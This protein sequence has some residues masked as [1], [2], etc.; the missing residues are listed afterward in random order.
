MLWPHSV[1]LTHPRIPIPCQTYTGTGTGNGGRAPAHPRTDVPESHL[2]LSLPQ[3]C[4]ERIEIYSLVRKPV[5]GSV[6]F[7][8]LIK[9][10]TMPPRLAPSGRVNRRNGSSELCRSCFP[11]FHFIIAD[12]APKREPGAAY[13][14]RYSV[15]I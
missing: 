10:R 4:Y 8:Q 14:H 5:I 6:R 2:C 11:S 7:Q 3:V 9:S 12:I 15:G 13:S 1:A